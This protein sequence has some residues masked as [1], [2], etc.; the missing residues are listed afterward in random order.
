MVAGPVEI[1]ALGG[2]DMWFEVFGCRL[3][4]LIAAGKMQQ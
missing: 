2:S 4:L 3:Y 1:H